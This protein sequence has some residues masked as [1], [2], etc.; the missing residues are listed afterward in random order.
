MRAS[1]L[2]N[3]L[4]HML[5]ARENVLIK[6]A[7]GIGKSDIVAAAAAKV[8]YDLIISHPVISDPVDYKGLP[9]P[10][11]H[12]GADFVPFGELKALINADKPTAYFLDDLGQAP[13]LV[14]AAAMQLLLAR[15]ING[16]PVSP[17][18]SFVAATNRKQDKAAVSGILEPV[19]SRFAT[20]VELEANTEE[21]TRWALDHDMPTEIIQFVRFKPDTILKFQPNPDIV[22]SPSPRTIAAAGRMITLKLPDDLEYEVLV[23]AIGEGAAVE[24]KAF[25]KVYR[26]LPSIESILTSPKQAMLPKDPSTL[27][28]VS[29]LVARHTTSANFDTVAQ[30]V[31]RLP[32]EFQVMLVKDAL[33]YDKT[34]PKNSRSFIKWA[35][36]HHNLMI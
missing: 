21:W 3:L 11:G 28:A 10:D 23:G 18:V 8:G 4:E 33:M 2:Q 6:G 22:N 19:K 14:Q 20:I 5:P 15:Q 9:L 17:F 30:Y 29:G 7:P 26:N 31:D 1:Q 12:G 24:L 27:Y 25:L 35:A 36:D 16:M 34:I 32:V 13:P